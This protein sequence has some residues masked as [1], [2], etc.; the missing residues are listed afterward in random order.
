MEAAMLQRI[1]Q[2]LLV[3]V[4][5]FGPA[6]SAHAEGFIDLNAGRTSY[7]AGE[8][9]SNLGIYVEKSFGR[10][11]ILGSGFKTNPGWDSVF[12][13]MG[14]NQESG[15]GGYTQYSLWGGQSCDDDDCFNTVAGGIYHL[16]AGGHTLTA[17]IEK[18]AGD[19]S[20][21][22]YANAYA[23]VTPSLRIGLLYDKGTIVGPSAKIVFGQSGFELRLV[24][25]ICGQNEP[26]KWQAK[27]AYSMSF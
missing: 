6:L 25:G 7:G 20:L 19:P 3:L 18:Y 24:G 16:S 22:V 2:I 13:G 23:E 10:F 9:E 4:L 17:Y 14:V 27:I 1:C 26:A 11:S 15:S 8:S 5:F 21:Y 12:L